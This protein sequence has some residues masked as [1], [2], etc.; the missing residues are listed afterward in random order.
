MKVPDGREKRDNDK[1]EWQVRR[2]ARVEM[3]DER[4]ADRRLG[5]EVTWTIL[6]LLQTSALS[7]APS[8][9]TSSIEM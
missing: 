6:R 3:E 5:E 4:W 1:Q 7:Q 2:E 8:H 9:T